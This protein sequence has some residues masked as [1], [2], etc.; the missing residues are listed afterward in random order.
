MS[1]VR[2]A[3]GSAVF[4]PERL[5]AVL[6]RFKLSY[7]FVGAIAARL[8]GS[9]LVTSIAEIIPALTPQNFEAL[10]SALTHLAARRYA[11]AVPEGLEFDA[12]PDALA[13]SSEWDL[14]TSC[15]R[16]RM[17]FRAGGVGYAEL[18][19]NAVRFAIHGDEIAV[20]SLADLVRLHEA[21]RADD[22]A[23]QAAALRALLA[24]QQ[25]VPR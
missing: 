14:L 5:V 3:A 22:D 4:H 8:H 25:A 13:G 7:V 2:A 23:A 6:G 21:P 15:G 1:A 10:T 19:P 18:A 24:R 16:L 11:E 9:P 20:A 17:A 12:S